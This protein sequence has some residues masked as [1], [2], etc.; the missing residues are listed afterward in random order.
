[1]RYILEH[2]DY[3]TDIDLFADMYNSREII[4]LMCDDSIS[5]EFYSAL[6]NV[7]WKKIMSKE[8]EIIE[9]LKHG[10]MRPWS[11]SWRSAGG[12]IAEIRN[13][14]YNKHEDYMDFYCGGKEG[15]VSDTVKEAFRKL[16]WENVKHDE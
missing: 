6:C 7:D 5:K 3:S 9:M 4:Y 1:M 10:G 8:E 12:Y 2:E 16:G 14:Y 11:C 13:K 15:I